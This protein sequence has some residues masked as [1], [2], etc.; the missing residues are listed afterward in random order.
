[1][2]RFALA[3]VLSLPAAA[4]FGAGACSVAGK[5]YDSSGRPL[6]NAV[7]RLVDLQTRQT[8][9][10]AADANAD[11]MFD[12]LDAN[13]GGHYRIDVLGPATI[14]TGTRIPTRSIVGMTGDF[15][16]SAGELAHQDVHAQVY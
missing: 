16:C 15:S 13:G 1:M 4:A 6:Q 5:A 2:Y 14:V 8:A 12:G 10:R 3:L 7:L 9:F 11:F